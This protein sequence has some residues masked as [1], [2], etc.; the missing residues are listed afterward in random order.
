[1][2]AVRLMIGDRVWV[3]L[4][5]SKNLRTG[6]EASQVLTTGKHHLMFQFGND[7]GFANNYAGYEV[8]IDDTIN[9]ALLESGAP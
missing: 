8:L 9:D 1:M 7:T 5:S 2:F 6:F 4:F 3:P